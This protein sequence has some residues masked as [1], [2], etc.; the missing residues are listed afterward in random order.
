V[1]PPIRRQLPFGELSVNFHWMYSLARLLQLL[2]LA[3]PPLAMVAQLNSDIGAGKML[4][5]LGLSVC[6]FCIGYLLQQ[7]TGKP[8]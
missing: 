6:L 4:Q 7:Y 8:H 1:T 3:I 2:A 5:F